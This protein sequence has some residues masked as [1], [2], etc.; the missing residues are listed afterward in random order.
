MS[1]SNAVSVTSVFS[2]EIDIL[3]EDV[4]KD[5]TCSNMAYTKPG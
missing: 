1:N 3:M 2:I 5:E 4:E